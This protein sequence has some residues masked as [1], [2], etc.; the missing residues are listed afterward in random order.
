MYFSGPIFLW[1]RESFSLLKQA[2]SSGII[3]WERRRAWI[4]DTCVI[5]FVVIVPE[6]TSPKS[7]EN[8]RGV[9]AEAVDF[10]VKP[11]RLRVW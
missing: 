2:S 9:E 1:N 8:A 5:S 11:S 10:E 7:Y 6:G 4:V 3:I